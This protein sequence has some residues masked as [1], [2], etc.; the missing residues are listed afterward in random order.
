M[1]VSKL[2]E[3]ENF[4]GYEF[5]DKSKLEL[6]LTH[7]SFSNENKSCC[8]ECN[9]RIEYLGDA[10]LELVISH[11]IYENFPEMHEGE[12][13]KLRARSVCETTLA[14]KA[15]E[16]N[17]GKYLHLGK[18]EELNGG[19]ERDSLLADAYEAVIGAVYLDGGFLI[20]KEYIY[21]LLKEEVYG[22]KD[23]FKKMDYKTL[24]QETLQKVSKQPIEYRL[25]DQY[26]PD[27]DKVFI[28]EVC[29]EGKALGRG[30]GKSKKEA[31]QAAANSALKS[32]K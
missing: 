25:V 3:L 18:G 6:A 5:K 24:L 11:L 7:S 30:K 26:G 15:R 4:I 19:R 16:I 10:V 28:S 9:E 23:S 31:E 13:T 14:K 27:H 12:M 32:L 22:F 20:A 1:N 17:L 29:H 21:S 2:R 8:K